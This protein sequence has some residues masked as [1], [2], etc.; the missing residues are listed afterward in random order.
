[1]IVMKHMT[2]ILVNYFQ[3]VEFEYM[4]YLYLLLIHPCY[5]LFGEILE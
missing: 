1:M 3:Y 4:A 2:L 5:C